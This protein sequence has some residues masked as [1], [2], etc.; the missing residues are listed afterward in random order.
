MILQRDCKRFRIFK[1]WFEYVKF[2]K[3]KQQ[4]LMKQLSVNK[5]NLTKIS[6]HFFHQKQ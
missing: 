1:L 3:T 5:C 6:Q 2:K 4:A